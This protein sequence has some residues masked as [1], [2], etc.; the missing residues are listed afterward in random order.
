MV[1]AFVSQG[2]G[3]GT[4]QQFLRQHLLPFRISKTLALAIKYLN[5]LSRS[6]KLTTFSSIGGWHERF[7]LEKLKLPDP[8]FQP[9]LQLGHGCMT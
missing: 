1:F 5:L 8:Y 3:W 2:E 4:S 9:P 7:S 6:G